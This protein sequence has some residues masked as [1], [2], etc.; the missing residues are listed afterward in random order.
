M[1]YHGP[2]HRDILNT[3][4]NRNGSNPWTITKGMMMTSNV[5]NLLPRSSTPVWVAVF[6]V[7]TLCGI[8]SCESRLVWAGPPNTKSGKQHP[9]HLEVQDAHGAVIAASTKDSH[10]PSVVLA[11]EH[12]YQPGDRIIVNGPS[13]MAIRVDDWIPECLVYLANPSEGTF[14]FDIPYGEGEPQTRSAFSPDSFAGQ[15]HRLTAR[16]LTAQEL[17]GYRNLAV[18]S[19]DQEP[20]AAEKAAAQ[21]RSTMYPHASTNSVSRNLPDFTARNAIDGMTQN[22][23]H[24]MWPY[25]SWGPEL[26]KDLWWKVDFGRTVELDKIRLMVRA[27][28]P[29]DSYWQSAVLEF[30][31]GGQLPIQITQ[32][33][34]FQE[35][36]FPKRAV[37]WVRLTKLVPADPARWCSF[38]EAEAW[39]R[40]LR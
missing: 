25:Q 38:I 12:E 9:F 3:H 31:D 20:P 35:F 6:S 34:E 37:S 26:R 39:G 32:S 17:S 22:G 21:T 16:E 33:A 24:G 8:F 10:G 5:G 13:R 29:H 7:L 15:W 11:F 30:S 19:C 28:F 18:N 4:L 36:T 1:H 40:D 2:I 27:D 14:S 23:H